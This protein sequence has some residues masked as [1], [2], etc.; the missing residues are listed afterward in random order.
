MLTDALS[1]KKKK[2]SFLTHFLGRS[3]SLI[4]KVD[5]LANRWCDFAENL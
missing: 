2:K 1:K 4:G 5:Y 3:R